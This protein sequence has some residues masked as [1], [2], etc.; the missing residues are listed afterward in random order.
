MEIGGTGT[1]RTE[2]HG[3]LTSDQLE[4][5]CVGGQ[6]EF[7]C[8]ADALAFKGVCFEDNAVITMYVQDGAKIII[9][10]SSI[11]KNV[12]IEI[13]GRPASILLASS[14]VEDGSIISC[15]D[16]DTEWFSIGST[17]DPLS[18]PDMVE[19][20]DW[21]IPVLPDGARLITAE[22]TKA[23]EEA[24]ADEA[25]AKINTEEEGWRAPL[26]ALAFAGLVGIRASRKEKTVKAQVKKAQE[27]VEVS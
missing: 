6:L 25:V 11:N 16:P 3:T 27:R 1:I 18:L 10:S 8:D 22:T 13:I 26:A 4:S 19:D 15:S 7:I 14:T 2:N 17:Y 9:G 23:D 5:V 12:S 20:E 21:L 24:A